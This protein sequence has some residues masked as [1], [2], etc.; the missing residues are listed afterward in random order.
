MKKRS[1]PLVPQTV[2]LQDGQ[3]RDIVVHG[4]K[5]NLKLR[6]GYSAGELLID[7]PAKSNRKPTRLGFA[8]SWKN[9]QRYAVETCADGQLK[10]LDI[11]IVSQ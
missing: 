9:G 10:D 1:Y 5:G 7:D 6:V 11:L 2:E 3:V 8:P 4:Q